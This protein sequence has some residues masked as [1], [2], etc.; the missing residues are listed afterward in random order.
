MLNKNELILLSAYALEGRGINP[1][2]QQTTILNQIAT[3][4]DFDKNVNSLQVVQVISYLLQYF[5][6]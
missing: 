6:E 4:L 1:G 5:S 3:L 2:T